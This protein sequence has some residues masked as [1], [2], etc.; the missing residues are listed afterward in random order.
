[1]AAARS[2]LRSLLEK[3]APQR[4][5]LES[6]ALYGELTSLPR[7]RC[8]LE[9]HVFAVWDFM[10]LLKGLQRHLT[11][12]DVAWLPVGDARMRRLINEIVLGEE[13][14][15]LP[16]GR[17]LSHFELY[18][19]AMREAGA[20]AS[21]VVAFAD[22][23]RRGLPITTALLLSRAPR[24][25]REFVMETLDVVIGDQ[26]HVLAAVFAVGRERMIPPM[27][28]QIV[29][30]LAD[31]HPQELQVFQLYLQRHI[32]LDRGEHSPAALEMLEGICADDSAKWEEA[33]EAAI[34]ALE[35]RRRLWDEVRTRLGSL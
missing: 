10:S 13:S 5:V 25:A 26:P 30:V 35:S 19:E 1:M 15:Q 17:V 27:F 34:S 11:R 29:Q 4:E 2:P 33:T 28:V 12:V 22:A 20:D 21:A 23:L 16:D 32:E 9:H 3:T 18:L 8:F 31:A 14:D 7:V 24:A 6:H